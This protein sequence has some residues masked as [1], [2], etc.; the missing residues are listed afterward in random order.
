LTGI[1]Y[2]YVPY[3]Q[4]GEP[5]RRAAIGRVPVSLEGLTP[6]EIQMVGHLMD[7][8][9]WMNPIL[10]HQV[11]PRIST[12]RRLVEE[13]VPHA[14][15]EERSELENYRTVLDIQNGFFTSQP[16]KNH[17]LQV[18]AER[19]RAIAAE[20]RDGTLTELETVIDL[21]LSPQE[22]HA[23]VN[24]YPPD[25]DEVE[26]AALGELS[27]IVNSTVVRTPEG[28]LDVILNET[29]YRSIL[30][31]A[32]EHLRRARDLAQDV[33]FRL[34]LDAKI[35][36]MESGSDE[37]RR[38]ADAAWVQHQYPIDIVISSAIEVYLDGYKNA[39]GAA[40]SAVTRVN[41]EG[42]QVL[43]EIIDQVPALEANAPWTH[44][45][46]AIKPDTLPKL[47]NV[48]VLTWSGDYI[49][50]PLTTLAQSLPN[51][52]WVGQNLGS[53]NTVF[54]NTSRLV[55]ESSGR[56]EARRFLLA[57]SSE[58]PYD[59]FFQ[60]SQLHSTLHEIGHACGAMASSHQDREPRAYFEEEYSWLEETRAEL[61][62]LWSFEP[63]TRAGLF[64]PSIG[65][66][67]YDAFL[68]RMVIGL[69]FEPL[70]AHIMARNG[71]FH[72][73]DE[74][75]CIKRSEE[76]GELKFEWDRV[77]GVACVN[78]LLKMIADIRSHGD[79]A[80]AIRFRENYIY[81]DELQEQIKRRNEDLPLGL[82]LIFPK[83]KRE[84]GRYHPELIY[85]DEFSQQEKFSLV[86]D[87][88]GSPIGTGAK[89][90]EV[91]P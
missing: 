48:D 82:G 47:R 22:S 35:T 3:Q 74:Q 71:I 40:A 14:V 31:M 67:A 73:L 4:D 25:I 32:L 77:S 12:V 72:F 53:M 44:K 57:S 58:T 7:A 23:T 59:E 38:V 52:A 43:R 15:G 62:G 75:G 27:S 45:R 24:L 78:E 89:R 41:Q 51:E 19:L 46:E 70:Q 5:P 63:L 60:A 68:L 84:D 56:L 26:F 81:R 64:D 6:D 30:A 83:L 21:M 61:F 54:V 29:R 50:S 33:G 9:D 11:D 91:A 2:S 76:R 13:L 80:A 69:E 90:F 18:P 20:S 1:K 10:R 65:R 17:L 87:E 66:A 28:G 36:E 86:F 85:P 37:A 42:E 88:E 8:S 79:K 16:R 49:H 34:Y 55:L 39:R